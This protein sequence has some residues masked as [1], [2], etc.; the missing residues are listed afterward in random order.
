MTVINSWLHI[1]DSDEC[2]ISA[3]KFTNLTSR[4]SH[5]LTFVCLYV[6]MFLYTHRMEQCK[7]WQ[8]TDIQR[9]RSKETAAVQINWNTSKLPTSVCL[10][11]C[12]YHQIIHT[13]RHSSPKQRPPFF[14]PISLYIVSQARF[15]MTLL[16]VLQQKNSF[17]KEI[18]LNYFHHNTSPT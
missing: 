16:P 12:L 10:S 8:N 7:K 9:S 13:S 17:K 4:A 3:P 5:R 14:P 11:A 2:R 6:C 18:Q 1:T 15:Y